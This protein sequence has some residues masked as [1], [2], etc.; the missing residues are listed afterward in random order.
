[1]PVII[2]ATTA[3]QLTAAR[4][5][6]Q[7]YAKSLSIDLCFQGFEQELATL[8][9]KYAPPQGRLLLALGRQRAEGCVGVR[10]LAP[11]VCE[12]KRLYVRPVS[13]RSGIGRLLADAAIDA[14]RAIGYRQMRLDT[15]SSMTEAI[16]LYTSL[17]FERV[18]PY[19]ENPASSAIFMELNL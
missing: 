5:L 12:M 15:L 13:R 6:F 1:M 18:P 17:G 2:E 14:A 9:G 4:E 16:A 11:T 10:P 7:E 3:E 19:Y 8:P